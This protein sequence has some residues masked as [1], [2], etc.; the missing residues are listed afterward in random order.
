MFINTT[1]KVMDRVKQMSRALFFWLLLLLLLL[2][3]LEEWLMCA[4]C[5]DV[6]GDERDCMF[7]I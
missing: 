7:S 1:T 2:L 4:C 5:G 6:G 3:L